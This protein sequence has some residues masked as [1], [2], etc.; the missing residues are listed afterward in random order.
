MK[1]DTSSPGERRLM[2]HWLL[3]PLGTPPHGTDVPHTH[4]AGAPYPTR[5][6]HFVFA[7]RALPDRIVGQGGAARLPEDLKLAVHST[8]VTVSAGATTTLNT[9]AIPSS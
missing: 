1:A 9:L 6:A 7:S 2:R 5:P 4:V 8:Q 3:Q